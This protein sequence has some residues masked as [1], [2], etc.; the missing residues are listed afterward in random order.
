[1]NA[2]I[3]S[4]FLYNGRRGDLTARRR[5]Q[6]CGA[7]ARADYAHHAD[8]AGRDTRI[9]AAGRHSSECHRFRQRRR[10][11]TGH[12]ESGRDFGRSWDSRD[13]DSCRDTGPDCVRNRIY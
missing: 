2:I 9:H 1:M 10:Q 13:G 5:S 7:R 11:N 4:L 8:R 6:C 3:S 12:A